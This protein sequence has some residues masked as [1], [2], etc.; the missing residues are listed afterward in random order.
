MPIM[1]F[2]ELSSSDFLQYFSCISYNDI[3]VWS[4]MDTKRKMMRM[5]ICNYV[6]AKA[7]RCCIS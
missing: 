7:K 6:E 2:T 5:G 4:N 1:L 3:Q